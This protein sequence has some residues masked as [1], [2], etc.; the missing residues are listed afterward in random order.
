MYIPPYFRE[1]DSQKLFDFIE[2]HSF[3]LLVSRWNDEPFATHMPFLLDRAGGPQGTLIGHVARANPH[4]QTTDSPV[5]AVFSGPHAYVSPTWYEAENVVPTWNYT[6]VHVYGP[7]EIIESHGKTVQV[8]CDMVTFY[9]S[10]LPQ[11]WTIRDGDEYVDKL[12]RSIVAFRIPI[13]RMEGKWKLNQNQPRERREKVVR[14]LQSREGEN[15]RDVA[16]LMQKMLDDGA[17]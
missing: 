7:L 4:W 15:A 1:T 3:G 2:Q 11:P 9:E 17:R 12:A 14:V 8:V 16:E 10:S 5:L 13:A 6:A